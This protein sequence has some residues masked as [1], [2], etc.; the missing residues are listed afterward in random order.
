[1]EGKVRLKDVVKDADED[2]D[3]TTEE[4]ATA[5]V[6]MID[7]LG[8]LNQ[9]NDRLVE[10]LQDKSLSDRSRKRLEGSLEKNR[11]EMQTLLDDVRISKKQI[12]RIV[13][14]L[15]SLIRRVDK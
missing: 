6:K 13:M 9:D 14:R 15:K 1:E 10:Q 5:I 11:E 12:D 2:D 8:K 7:R 4:R 3:R